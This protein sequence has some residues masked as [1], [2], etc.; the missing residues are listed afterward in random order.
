MKVSFIV[1]CRD[2]AEFVGRTVE[3]VL[4]Q[5]YSPMEIVLSDQGSVDGTYEIIKELADKYTG[6]NTVRVLQCPHI[7]FKGMAGLNMHLNWLNDQITGDIVIMCS[8]DDMNHPDRAKYTVEAFEKNNPSYVG[9]CVEYYNEKGEF[10]GNVTGFEVHTGKDCFVDPIKN[11]TDLVGSSASSA[12]SKDLFNKYGPLQG[13]ESQDVLLPFFATLERGI[14]YVNKRLHAYFKRCDE[15]NTGMEGVVRGAEKEYEE[16]KSQFEKCDIEPEKGQLYEKMLMA[17]K[18]QHVAIETNNYHYTSNFYAILR[19]I[20][21]MNLPVNDELQGA[22]IRKSVEAAN[23][24]SI[25][26]DNLTMLKI[27]PNGMRV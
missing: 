9:T 21:D 15:N 6:P 22:L 2:K 11:V 4:A 25:S 12:W 1:P 5:T 8:A 3:S 10:T 26:R 23:I 18:K 14:F 13:V 24:W 19:R 17:K 7:E 16:F 27:Q 20:T